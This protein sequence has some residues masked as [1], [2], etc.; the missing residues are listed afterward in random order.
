M[1]RTVPSRGGSPRWSRR[2]LITTCG[3]SLLHWRRT[4]KNCDSFTALPKTIW[5]GG[6]A[7]DYLLARHNAVTFRVEVTTHSQ[8][9]AEFRQ[10]GRR[11]LE[12]L[13]TLTDWR[14]VCNP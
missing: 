8:R 14:S 6:L 9:L 4:T 11:F 7:R 3:W 12:N 5:H 1:A 10:T 2:V 13:N